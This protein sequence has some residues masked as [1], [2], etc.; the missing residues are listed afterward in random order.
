MKNRIVIA[1]DTIHRSQL[2]HSLFISTFKSHFGRARQLQNLSRARS[3]TF[4]LIKH[5][6]EWV[7]STCTAYESAL[8]QHTG[9]QRLYLPIKMHKVD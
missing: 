4:D 3:M 2:H 8:P 9:I 6:L 1:V 7:A 5:P